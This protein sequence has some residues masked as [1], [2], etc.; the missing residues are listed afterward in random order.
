MLNRVIIYS[1]LWF[2]DNVVFGWLR[3]GYNFDSFHR[4][5]FDSIIC[6]PSL[7]DCVPTRIPSLWQ[8]C[9]RALQMIKWPF[10]PS[11]L[12]IFP[13]LPPS[14]TRYEGIFRLYTPSTTR[15]PLIGSRSHRLCFPTNTTTDR[16]ATQQKFLPEVVV[17]ITVADCGSPLLSAIRT[18]S[19]AILATNVIGAP[20]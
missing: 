13:N 10:C 4:F 9:K 3:C 15:P 20:C 5:D 16:R 12:T 17:W 7:D 2:L 11:F 1:L 19:T 8:I 6:Y 14:S 18:S